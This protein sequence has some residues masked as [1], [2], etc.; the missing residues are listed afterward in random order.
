MSI[1]TLGYTI[2]VYVSTVVTYFYL[3]KI[4]GKGRGWASN[5]IVED[6]SSASL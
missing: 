2:V 5:K 4:A 6:T 3:L 1:H